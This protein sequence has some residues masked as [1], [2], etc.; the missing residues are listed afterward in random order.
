MID[1][2]VI[3]EFG[4]PATSALADAVRTAKQDRPLAP[5]TVVVPSNFAGLSA[6]RRLVERTPDGADGP[7]GLAHVSF[8]TPFRAAEL[9]AAGT[10]DGRSPLT[11]PVLAAAVRSVLRDDPG[12]FARVADHPAT[13]AALVR[14]YAEL[15]PLP[16]AELD[17]I[18]AT[19]PVRGAEAVRVVR[20]V[21][22]LLAHRYDE[23]DVAGAA[24]RALVEPAAARRFGALVWWLPEPTSGPVDAF[25]VALAQALPTTAIVGLSGDPSADAPVRALVERAGGTVA[26][27]AVAPPTAAEI[28][29]VSDPDD[30]VRA[31]VR[32]VLALAHEGVAFD[33]IGILYPSAQPY[34]R[35]L[36]E[37]LVDAEIPHHGPSPHPLR[38]TA[39]GRTLLAALA[40]PDHQWR[41]DLVLA[42]AG[43]APVHHESAPA[44]VGRWDACSR[45]AGVVAELDEWRSRLTALAEQATADAPA[46]PNE[47]AAVAEAARSLLSFVDRVARLLAAIEEASTWSAM[48]AAAIDLLHDLLPVDRD[49]WPAAEVDAALRIE[50]G[51]ARLAALDGVEPPDH[52]TFRRAAA[53]ELDQ[54]AA[55]MGRFGEGVTIGPITMAAGLDLDAVFLLGLTE[56]SCPAP[57]GD[58]PV[59]ADA[60]RTLVPGLRDAADRLHHQH[61]CYLAAL[62]SAPAGRRVL[63]MPRGD[64]RSGAHRLPSRWLLDSATEIEGLAIRRADGTTVPRVYASDFDARSLRQRRATLV[65]SHAAGIRDAAPPLS[66]VERDAATLLRVGVDSAPWLSPG[67]HRGVAGAR[68]RASDQ[69]TEWDGNVA[70]LEVPS[71]ADGVTVLSPTALEEWARCGFRYFLGRILHLADR[72]EPE[73]IVQLSGL[74]RGLLL[75]RILER[76][77]GEALDRPEGPPHPD[78]PW[79]A[80]DRA[81]LHQIAD[82][83]F[84]R[85]ESEGRTGRRLAWAHQQRVLHGLLDQF[86]AHDDDYRRQTATTPV[87]VELAFGRSSGD[88]ALVLDLPDGR[89][90]RLQG[91][92]D[93]V[94][95]DAEGRRWVV[96]YKTGSSSYLGRIDDDPVV[97]GT[98]LQ[99]GVYAEAAR[100][101]GAAE[102][103]AHYWYVDDRGQRLGYPWTAERRERLLDAI[104]ATVEGIESGHFPARP[105]EFNWFQ[106]TNDNCG[107]CPFDE[108]CPVDRA[109]QAETKRTD[110]VL[111]SRV[112]LLAVDGGGRDA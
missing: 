40:L 28:I 79:P 19:G 72:A 51:L 43:G 75:H 31:A 102:V 71:P 26:G 22:R 23:A 63:L 15:S 92:A 14:V 58:D 29:V 70:G 34:L 99:L 89:A 53:A 24:S 77:V 57:A 95:V 105:G 9:L 73:R 85:A 74:D 67:V 98:R 110:H 11:R 56:G 80:A 44:P 35:S 6:R 61:H 2:T 4:R 41:R 10:L 45:A 64:L 112:R 81:R 12:G 38:E 94:D 50:A 48:A 82:R 16:L 93:R 36:H 13:E 83:V 106:G 46:H 59:L 84:A 49:R 68:A 60:V 47:A 96:D 111:P 7:R 69:F 42:L 32:R 100:A 52:A 5:V 66:L 30:E 88:P 109:E 33:R 18:E 3:V 76:F 1:R 39:T 90:V 27:R 25:V 55:R 103:A 37:R 20:A 97:G 104:A 17:L 78:E 65:P 21:R 86:L 8:L 91:Q 107:G 101:R 108:L 54:P 62:G 87:A